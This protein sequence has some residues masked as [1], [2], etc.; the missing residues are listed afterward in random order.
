MFSGGKRGGGKRGDGKRCGDELGGG[1]SA[2]TNRGTRT[3][4]RSVCVRV[5]KHLA[6]GLVL[7]DR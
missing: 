2:R 1:T 3:R 7:I 6:D 5:R 4:A